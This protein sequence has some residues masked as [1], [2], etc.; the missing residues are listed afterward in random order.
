MKAVTVN[1]AKAN[2]EG[3]IDRVIADVE[4]TII[5]TDTG[6]QIVLLSIDEFNSW[7]ETL[8]LLSNPVNA[9]HLRQSIAEASTG[10]VTK[11]DLID[12]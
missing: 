11:K 4:P 10:K 7:K 5:C 6:Q 12:V 3:L 9:A 1:E 8:Y 2:L